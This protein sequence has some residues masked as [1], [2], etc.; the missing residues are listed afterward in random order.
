MTG[1]R[2]AMLSLL[3]AAGA[4]SAC[5]G[6]LP[7]PDLERM[8]DQRGYR[9]Y[10]AA[11]TSLFADGRSMRAPPAGTI[12]R[13]VRV[14]S[15]AGPSEL[16]PR[17]VSA[18][19]LERGRDRFDLFCATCHGLRGDG[20]SPVAHN[21]ELRRPASLLDPP[22]TTFAPARIFEIASLGYGL[23]PG[24]ASVLDE[25]DRWSVV[26]YVGAL[27]LSQR[28]RLDDLPRDLRARAEAA[29]Q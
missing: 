10:E 4:A 2:W 29:L 20:E 1:V 12:S 18:R 9:P 27:Q 3:A 6:V 17:A 7:E 5:E 22:V 13:G 28:A 23:M 25:A 15:G 14:A 16:P 24:Y 21:M 19:A 8:I 26:A 11:P